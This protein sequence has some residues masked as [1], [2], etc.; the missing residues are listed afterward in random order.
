LASSVRTGGRSPGCTPGPVLSG[1]VRV[2]VGVAVAD[3]LERFEVGAGS[4]G[5]AECPP[6]ATAST[7]GIARIPTNRM[8]TSGW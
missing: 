1:P 6:Q 5:V 8:R 7:A 3:G 4:G 2:G